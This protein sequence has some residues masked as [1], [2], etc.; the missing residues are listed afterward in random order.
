MFGDSSYFLI[1]YYLGTKYNSII[2]TNDESIFHMMDFKDFI[3]NIDTFLPKFEA[4]SSETNT[5]Y[6]YFIEL[7]L[8]FLISFLIIF[9]KHIKRKRY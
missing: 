5:N 2:S 8:S 7:F 3:N 4:V 9:T 6:I 1:H